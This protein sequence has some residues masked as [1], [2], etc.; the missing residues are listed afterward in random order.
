MSTSKKTFWPDDIRLVI[1]ASM[2]FETGGQPEGAESPF[3]GVPISEG[4]PDL[5]ARTWFDY[6]FKEGIPRMLDLWDKFGIKVTSH[7]VGDAVV[8]YPE[9][10]KEIVERGHE[11]SGHGMYWSSQD[12]M[13]YEE[14]KEFVKAGVD[15]V[16][17]VTGFRTVGYNCNWL[18][19]SVHTLEVLQELGFLYHIDDLSRD[20]PFTVKVREKDFAVVPYTIRCNDIGLIEGRNFST[21][22]FLKQMIMEF[23]QQ[24]EEAAYRRRMMSFSLHDRI[25]GQANVANAVK[26]FI[27]YANKHKGVTFMRKDE[28]A[29]IALDSDITI[30]EQ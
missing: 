29:K 7:M 28:I 11:A 2:Q 17:K 3:S 23:D 22:Q 20:E 16:E 8:K 25:G 27:E 30:R 21:D 13:S 18:R 14:E 1:S 12:E 5:P 19:R 10:A 4:I 6:G 9:L 15:A 26:Q 24:Y